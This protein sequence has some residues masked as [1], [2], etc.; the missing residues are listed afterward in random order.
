MNHT[1]AAG[2][3]VHQTVSLIMS[4]KPLYIIVGQP[5]TKSM[6]KMMEQMTQM[7]APIKTTTWGGQHGLLALVLDDTDYKSIPKLTMQTTPLVTQPDAINQGITNQSTPFKILTLQ[8]E[9]KTLQKEFDLQEG[10][11][12]IG[13]QRIIDCVKEQTQ[14]TAEKNAKQ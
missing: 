14:Q 9:M 4:A 10:V 3:S 8:A 7:V 5:T 12:N 1:L 13:V 11:I 2:L 6:N